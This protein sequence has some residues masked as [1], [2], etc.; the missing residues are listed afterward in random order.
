MKVNA[1]GAVAPLAA[2]VLAMSAGAPPAAWGGE[3][4]PPPAPAPAP[5]PAAA[6]PPPPAPAPEASAPALEVYLGPH[7]GVAFSDLDGWAAGVSLD[8]VDPVAALAGVQGGAFHVFENDVMLGVEGDFSYLFG[9]EDDVDIAFV[10]DN[11]QVVSGSAGGA[12]NWLASARLRVGRA[13]G[14]LTP[15]ATGGIGFARWEATGLPL[16][17]SSTEKEI[18]VGP[19]AGGGVDWRLDQDWSLRAEG[20]YFF[21]DDEIRQ[22]GDVLR[23]EG[24]GVVRVAANFHF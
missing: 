11:E 20:L 8:D 19:V 12:V 5:P 2:V 6:A 1:V 14:A 9:G 7:A 15:F 22:G 21:F 17:F 13:Y 3:P 24:V 18:A 16:G 10:N 4:P 23:L